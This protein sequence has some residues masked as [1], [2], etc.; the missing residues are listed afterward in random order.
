MENITRASRIATSLQARLAIARAALE[1][2]RTQHEIAIRAEPGYIIK[3]WTG[4]YEKTPP[5]CVIPLKHIKDEQGHD[6]VYSTFDEAKAAI[7]TQIAQPT[8]A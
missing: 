5:E 1:C 7:M 4:W 2:A 8:N 3:T 6:A